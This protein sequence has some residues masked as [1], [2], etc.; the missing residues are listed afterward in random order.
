MRVLI[1]DFMLG[2]GDGYRF[3]EYDPKP[4]MLGIPWR[5]PIYDYL[6][7]QTGNGA[8][9][10]AASLKKAWEFVTRGGQ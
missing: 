10:S 3:K 5:A 9:V 6:R 4:L 8:K 1:N 7:D 2:G